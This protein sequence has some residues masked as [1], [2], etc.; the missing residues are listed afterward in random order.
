V[1]WNGSYRAKVVSP[2]DAVRLVKS[3]DRVT[4]SANA[5]VPRALLLALC[6]RSQELRNVEILELLTLGDA[7]FDRPEHRH[8]FRANALF[9]GA[10]LREAVN[11]GR[12]DYTPVFLSEIPKLFVERLPIDVALI[13]VSPPDEHG[14]CSFGVSV[15]V[16]KPAAE[17][18]RLV[19]AEVNK[20]CPRTL[21]N[22]FIHVSKLAAI[23]EV[24]RELP[25]LPR[26]EPS[27]V[28]KR[29]GANVA[30]LVRDGD[31]LQLG[32]GSI[33][34]AVLAALSDRRDLGIHTEMFS[35]GVMELVES[36]VITGDKKAI[37]R[38]KV[39]SSFLMGSRALYRWAHD[40]S[41]IEMH[42]SDYTNDPVIVAQNDHIVAVN[43]AIAVDLTGQ[44][45]ADAIGTRIY[46]GIGGQVDFIR[47]AS[48]A[49]HGRPIIALP[50]TA[51]AGAVSRICAALPEGASVVTTRGDVRFV[52]TE[53]GIAD[54]WGRSLRER[55]R[56]LIA[57]ADPQ[58]RDDL[59]AHARRM[60][61]V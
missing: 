13:Q 49:A 10:N 6:A 37:H 29:I 34:D 12:A 8:A 45:A 35:D 43:S 9:V 55:A 16:I 51:K 5:G 46:S 56:A 7:P 39:V 23:V 42:P 26:E 18:S 11:E 54:L 19:I 50:S 52:V 4:I 21:G 14:Y 38:G 48:R 15:D 57:I 28:A 36:G 30:S 47:G 32:I 2:E 17:H 1:S 24:D 53:H 58:F 25:E 27:E 40:N 44:V 60:R 3:G 31:T 22:S 61:W 59:A 41:M 33:P 20:A